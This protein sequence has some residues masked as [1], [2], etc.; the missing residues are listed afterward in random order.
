ML[1]PVPVLYPIRSTSQLFAMVDYSF[2]LYVYL[3]QQGVHRLAFSKRIM[4]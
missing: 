3:L 2:P 1:A 4:I